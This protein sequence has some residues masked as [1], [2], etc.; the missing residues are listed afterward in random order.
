MKY[1]NIPDIAKPVSRL[2]QGTMMM[3]TSNLE[4]GFAILDACL[5]SG[6]NTFD[7]AHVYGNGESER[8]LGRWMK[9]R[10][11]R[12]KVVILGK[13]AHHNMDRKR[14][15]TF[16]I[17]ADVQDSLARLQVDHIDLYLLH[18]DD[19]E[20]PVGPIVDTLNQ[21]HAAGRI[22]A[23]GGSNWSVARL[24]E[25]NDYAA[26]NGLKPFV[27]SSPNFSL[28]VQA[29]PPWP[30]CVSL[31]GPE[32]VVNRQWYLDNPV[33][34][35]T[36]SSLAGGFFSGRFRRD[37]L[38][39]FTEGYDQLCVRVYCHEG[40][41]QRLDRVNELSNEKGITVPQLALSY[42]LNQPQGI[43]ALVGSRNPQEVA[44]N[45]AASEVELTGQEVD[46]LD[47]RA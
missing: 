33:T 28:G 3:N 7:T 42:V 41:F 4:A 21:E 35:F 8:V 34:L 30:D 13:G 23:F 11:V 9:D 14:V 36:W 16:D 10:G 2:V 45:V 40:N 47:L 20:K 12:D 15:T 38:D 6:L 22:G 32:N 37:N 39:T 44:V 18:R 26:A 24:Q 29:E 27:A 46:W 17:Q 25:A 19:P 5:E 31:S 1:S 43:H